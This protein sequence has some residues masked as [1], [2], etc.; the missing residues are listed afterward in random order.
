MEK[1][2]LHINLKRLMDHIQV[3]STIG[4]LPNGG[5]R[6]LALT[7]EDKEMREIFIDW[8]KAIDLQVRVDDF[9][10]IYGRKEG[11]DKHAPAVLIGSHL[12]TQPEG[13]KYDG[14]LGVLAGLEVLTV[15]HENHITT[16]KPIELVCFTNEEGARFAPPILGA[17]G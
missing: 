2:L 11:K 13:G 8:M 14:I 7:D 15:L 12:D 10:N 1:Q 4:A 5:I 3:S 16:E 17:G 6:R 9:G